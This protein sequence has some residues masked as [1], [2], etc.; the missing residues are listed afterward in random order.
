VDPNS[1][2]TVI[3]EAIAQYIALIDSRVMYVETDQALD[4]LETI[5]EH[6]QALDE[7]LSRGGFLPDAWQANR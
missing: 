2:L 7:W 6:F 4:V 3:R 1:T 5:P